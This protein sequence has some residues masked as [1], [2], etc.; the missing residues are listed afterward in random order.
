MQTRAKAQEWAEAMEKGENWKSKPAK[1]GGTKNADVMRNE[2]FDCNHILGRQA[3]LPERPF[4]WSCNAGYRRGGDGEGGSKPRV[5]IISDS[6]AF[7]QTFW[8]LSLCLGTKEEADGNNMR[9][10]RTSPR[11]LWTNP[12]VDLEQK[13]L[14]VELQELIARIS[15]ESALSSETTQ[16]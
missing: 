7:I 11:K 14:S 9:E 15:P 8:D 13:S 3:Y 12:R 6:L 10:K 5:F 2:S 4:L 16:C 1:T